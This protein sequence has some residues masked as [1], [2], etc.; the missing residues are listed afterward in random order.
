MVGRTGK[1]QLYTYLYLT[2]RTK[3][4]LVETFGGKQAE[5]HVEFDPDQWESYLE[6]VH[7]GVRYLH[8][9]LH[10]TDDSER[11]ALLYRVRM[12]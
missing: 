12:V 3:G 5:H 11:V 2:G 10:A 4:T 6:R 9:I 1:V 8:E 7:R